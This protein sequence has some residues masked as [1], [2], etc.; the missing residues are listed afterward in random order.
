MQQRNYFA[1]FSELSYYI[2]MSGPNKERNKMTTTTIHELP[3]RADLGLITQREAA[4]EVGVTGNQF[5]YAVASRQIPFP[6][7]K[8]GNKP[9]LYYVAD[10]LIE[11]KKFFETKGD[12]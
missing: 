9:R 4:R 7:H 3:T 5:D 10:D 2:R 12:E 1:K 11:I 8:L 6:K